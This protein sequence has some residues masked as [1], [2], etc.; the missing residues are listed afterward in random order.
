M[1]GIL[2]AVVVFGMVAC[3]P[4]RPAWK[5]SEAMQTSA[6]MLAQLDKLEA[7]LHQGDAETD[8]YAVLVS[9]HAHAEEIA[10]KVTDEHVAEIHRLAV[11]QQEKLRQKRL[12]RKKAIAQLK[13]GYSK[14]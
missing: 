12:A 8:T 9:R 10:C 2:A 7:D 14:S 1:R 3:G 6:R 13:T 4:A 11:A 5:P